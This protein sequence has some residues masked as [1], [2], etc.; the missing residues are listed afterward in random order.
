MQYN[1]QFSAVYNGNTIENS[2]NFQVTSV[3]STR[4]EQL[5]IP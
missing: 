4:L 3:V 2:I 1:L 5:G